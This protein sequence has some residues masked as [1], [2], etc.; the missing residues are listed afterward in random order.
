[1]TEDVVNNNADYIVITLH[2]H[3]QVR[4]D[5]VGGSTGAATITAAAIAVRRVVM[6]FP[7]GN[8]LAMV[9]EAILSKGYT[10]CFAGWVRRTRISRLLGGGDSC[11]ANYGRCCNT[12]KAKY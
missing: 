7:P 8:T 12:H 10:S 5:A 6:V 3:V 9:F 2:I 4:A 11:R 1:M